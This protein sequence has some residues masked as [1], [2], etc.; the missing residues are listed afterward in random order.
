[1][2]Q[3]QAVAFDF[4]PAHRDQLIVAPKMMLNF[5][6]Q[7][8]KANLRTSVALASNDDQAFPFCGV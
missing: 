3:K 8:L 4:A 7:N 2:Q 6:F 5:E 1:M